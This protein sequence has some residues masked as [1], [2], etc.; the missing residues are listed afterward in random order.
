MGTLELF[1][2][3]VLFGL[4]LLIAAGQLAAQGLR[5]P[6]LKSQVKQLQREEAASLLSEFCGKEVVTIGGIGLECPV[7]AFGPAFSGIIDRMFHPERA[8]FGHSLGVGSDDVAVSDWSAETHPDLWGGTLLL[9]K[10][11]GKWIPVWYTSALITR[12]C[13]KVTLPSR[14]E[15]LLC[16]IEDGGMGHQ[17]HYLYSVDL[18]TPV[19][20]D[21][22]VMFVTNSFHDGCNAQQQIIDAVRWISDRRSL[23]V[24]IRT[25]EFQNSASRGCAGNPKRERPPAT[26]LLQFAVTDSGFQK[27]P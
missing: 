15:I 17:L 4:I 25:S 12:D 7:K 21:A 24:V 6:V 5:H 20:L 9:T 14:R 23:S 18:K 26:I 16:E 10:R 2:R 19:D 27:N 1:G 3:S 8:L 22:S 11:N 13:E